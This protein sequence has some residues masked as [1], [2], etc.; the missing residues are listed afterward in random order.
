MP[1]FKFICIKHGPD[2]PVLISL[3]LMTDCTYPSL[4]SGFQTFIPLFNT[5]WILQSS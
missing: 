3:A 4:M 1:Y 5:G 2:H